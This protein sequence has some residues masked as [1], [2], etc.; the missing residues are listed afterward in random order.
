MGG[1]SRPIPVSQAEHQAMQTLSR[2][3]PVARQA[4]PGESFTSRSIQALDNDLVPPP[5]SGTAGPPISPSGS[6]ARMMQGHGARMSD[7]TIAE[8]VSE[9]LM[10]RFGYSA[11]NARN[12]AQRMS[13]G[14]TSTEEA[15]ERALKEFGRR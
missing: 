2:P 8:E 9:A 10:S 6:F 5:P 4:V 1:Q 14:A 3:S 11:Q 15:L 13:I 12:M 7:D